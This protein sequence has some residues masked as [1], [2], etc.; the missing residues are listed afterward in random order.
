MYNNL[1]ITYGQPPSSQPQ[2]VA[3]ATSGSEGGGPNIPNVR[4]SFITASD[5][6]KF[7][8]L[9]AF[10]CSGGKYLTGEGAKEILVKS[11]LDGETLAQI[12]KLSNLTKNNYLTFP[13]FALAM[14]LTNLKL[15]KQD[16]PNTIPDSIR[17]EVMGVIEQIRA[18][19]QEHQKQQQ[20]QQQQTSQIQRA[21]SPHN[22]MMSH[23]QQ[24]YTGAQMGHNVVQYPSNPGI[25]NSSMIPNMIPSMMPFTQRM[26]PQQ[27][28]PQQYSTTGIVGN[29]EIPWAVTP[30]EKI[31]YREIFRQWDSQGLGYLTGEKAKEIL[32]QS[33]LP[34]NDLMQIWE[35]SDPNN[36]GKLNQD[37]FAVAMHLIYRK[38]NNYDIP[39]TLPPELIP[40]S[41]R[42]LSESVNMIKNMLKSD[43]VHN[44][45]VGLGTHTSGANYAKSR[46]F[47]STPTINRNDATGY[48]HMDDDNVYVSSSRHRV[49]TV[50]RSQNSSTYSSLSRSSSVSE[51]IGEDSSSKIS[52]LKKQIHEKQILLEAFSYTADTAPVS[53]D[54]SYSS[55]YNDV[56]ELKNKI[57]DVQRE[58]NE[59]ERSNPEWLNREFTRN[60]E[61]LGSLLEQ[62]K[63]LDDELNN[64]L[65]TIV[66]ELISRIRE[67]SSRIP[68]SKL[69]LFKLREGSGGGS[70]LNIIGT[71][72][73]GEITEADRIKA[74]AQAMIQARMAALTGKSVNFG[75]GGGGINPRLLEEETDRINSE[76]AEREFKVAEIERNI[77]KLQDS[78]IKASREREEIEDK[79]RKI[80]RNKRDRESEI[81]KW[82]DGIGVDDDVRRFI[83]DLKRDSS[84]SSRYDYSSDTYS[85]SR[86][87]SYNRKPSTSSTSSS[88]YTS[89]SNT[90]NTT[91]NSLSK[92]K[93]PEEREAFIKAEAER[94]MQERLKSLGVK[95]TSYSKST[96]SSDPDSPT[97]SDRLAREKAENAER[98]ARAEREAEERE[99]IRTE[100]LLAEKQKKAEQDA[101]KL[102]KMEEFE[103]REEERRN[104]WLAEAKELEKAK[105]RKAREKEEAMRE[106]ELEIERKRIEAAEKEKKL[107]EERLARIK[108]E[109]EERAAEEERRR[110]EQEALVENAKAAR[111]KAKKMEEEAKQRE[112]TAKREVERIK[113]KREDSTF[114]VKSF[115]SGSQKPSSVDSASNNPFLNLSSQERKMVDAN[116]NDTIESSNPFF[117]FTSGTT[118]QSN[119]QSSQ[120]DKHD[121][122]DDWNVVDEESSDD[123]FPPGNTKQ[124][125]SK[126]FGSSSSF[127]PPNFESV[128]T[129]L[130]HS[131]SSPPTSKAPIPNVTAKSDSI[132]PPPPLPPSNSNSIPPPP[133]PPPNSNFIPPPPPLPS[134]SSSIPPPP[135]LPNSNDIPPPPPL[136]SGSNAVPPAPPFPTTSTV[137]PPPPQPQQPLSSSNKSQSLPPPSSSRN[138]L[139]SQIQQGTKLRAT[140]TNDRSAPLVGGKTN[141]SNSSTQNSSGGASQPAAGM[142]GLSGLGALFAGG[143]PKLK[144]RGGIETGS[145]PTESSASKSSPPTRQKTMGRRVSADWFGNLSSDQ[146]AGE[147]TPKP[148]SIKT[149]TPVNEGN[150]ILGQTVTSP[151]SVSMDSDIDFSQE[152][153]VKSLFNYPGTG[154]ADDLKFGAGIVFVAHPSKNPSNEEWWYGSIEETGSK[155]WFPKNFVE[156][157][158]EEKEICKAKALYDYKAQNSTEL[159]IKAGNIVSILDKS[160]NDWWKAEFEGSKGY[161]PANYVEEITSSSVL[162]NTSTDESNESDG[163][164]DETDEDNSS[165]DE[166]SKDGSFSKNH[167]ITEIDNN[168]TQSSSKKTKILPIDI[169]KLNIQ[170]VNSPTTSSFNKPVLKVDINALTTGKLTRKPSLEVARSPSPTRLFGAS[171]IMSIPWMQLGDTHK[172]LDSTHLGISPPNYPPRPESPVS[173]GQG[174]SAVTWASIM[175][176]ETIK[177][178]SKEDRKRQEAIYELIS[179]EQSYLRDLQM[180]VEVFCGPLQSILSLDELGI[181]FS[182]IEDILLCNTAILSDLEQRQKDDKLFVNN[183]GD[184]LLKHSDELS[185]YEIY[186]GKQLNA[187]KFLQQK[188]NINK[189]FSEFLKKAQQDPKCGSLDLSS[190][191][192]KPMQR[193]TRYPLLIRQILH[194]TSKDHSDQE[195]LMKALHKAEGILE[196]TNEAAR[197]QENKLKLAEISRLVD[198][199]DLDEK[200]DLRSTTRSVGKRQF[201]LEGA[202]KKAKSGRNLFGY[203]FNDLLLLTQHNKKSVAKGYQYALYKPPILLNEIV[204]K[205]GQDETFQIIHIED[206]INLKA[207]SISAKQQWVNQLETASGYCLEVERKKQKKEN[208]EPVNSIGTLKVTVYEAVI[209]IEVHE[210]SSVNTYCQVQLNR[211]IFKTKVVK[212]DIFPHWNQY[213]M[214]SVTTL[215]DTLKLSVYQYD[216]YSEDEYLGK[217]EIGL[218]FLEHYGGNETDKIKLQLKDVAPGRPFGSISVY[219]NYKPF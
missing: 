12:W 29:A 100:R 122:D 195:D 34:Q 111:E 90:T 6:T 84:T 176:P 124:L 37:E 91:T 92:P 201:I 107:E 31:Q 93:S 205:S 102:R 8:E 139:L 143:I 40:P 106:K 133:P 77:S 135:P 190:F 150:N 46:S 35:L 214:F 54:S 103:K 159:D 39:T 211:Q 210:K 151:I 26:M 218:H 178:I 43:S 73:G 127:E 158:K 144:S 51:N 137:P 30:E 74:K 57:K 3:G 156:I 119:V 80:E 193:I 180:I 118:S 66:P 136:P 52:E 109:A 174:P 148:Q 70:D 199:E 146:L 215:E 130:P 67:T 197:E 216:K 5:Q 166:S 38:L 213:L 113:T 75:G 23:P 11:K 4:L 99:R 64:I 181:I 60:S 9:Y 104:Q 94:R 97:L 7:E 155:G 208:L 162:N 10:G 21:I 115:D 164:E 24:Q 62:H 88:V 173:P 152:F 212:D 45:S 206:V 207:S 47:T 86:D 167:N 125:A 149:E 134:N 126:I 200:L 18:I 120:N 129:N 161:V 36:N 183:V 33:G 25:Q 48:K 141:D 179:T 170:G 217:A 165:Q 147:E 117:K 157:Y 28:P 198:L 58:I 22:Q 56:Y 105:D 14:Y 59:K 172:D 184:I 140:K 61:E 16:L 55:D 128:K 108:R 83:Q 187:S 131:N 79:Y 138:A 76:K 209:P 194:Y 116:E 192:L 50:P 65:I 189:T 49:P 182:N 188:R 32:S 160:L 153:R 168:T 15:K 204:V 44:L 163:S 175:D 42:E 169:P 85:S 87:V 186:C 69:E 71:G 171:P 96:S 53:Y 202:L 101:E 27:N 177:D 154:G 81:R 121:D 112:E 132:P 17:N 78:V 142:G 13:E 98:K 82:E 110:I 191:L 89:I 95:K 63:N 2:I 185:C 19:E 196:S 203:L 145:S 114:S 219:L 20:K 41:S 1:Q 72:P 68:D 123:D